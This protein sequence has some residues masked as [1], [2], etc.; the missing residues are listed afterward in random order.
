M[1]SWRKVMQRLSLTA[2]LTLGLALPAMASAS[3]MPTGLGT[4]LQARPYQVRWTGD[5]T[6]WLGGFTGHASSKR[7]HFGRLRW[8]QWSGTEG[9]A[10]GADWGD[11]CSPDCA[12]G[13]YYPVKVTVHVF[14]P[15][16]QGVFT[17]MSLT[18]RDITVNPQHTITLDAV[19]WRA[20]WYW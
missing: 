15:N 2:A 9:H 13:T 6:G 16:A 4:P 10:W 11:N 8:T 5:Q 3:T 17:R 14:R 7:R 18:E 20:Y 1:P 12:E 19:H